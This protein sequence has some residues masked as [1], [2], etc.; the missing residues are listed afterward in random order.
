MVLTD[1]RHGRIQF[2]MT[3]FV[4]VLGVNRSLLLARAQLHQRIVVPGIFGTKFV[5]VSAKNVYETDGPAMFILLTRLSKS[6]RD[7]SS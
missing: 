4:D 1:D 2:F 3:C 6:I 5:E 7:L